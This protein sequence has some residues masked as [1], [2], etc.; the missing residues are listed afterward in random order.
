MDHGTPSDIGYVHVQYIQHCPVG[1]SV[2]TTN[3]DHNYTMSGSH[4]ACR[5]LVQASQ[6]SLDQV[7]RGTYRT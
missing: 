7:L 6:L 4:F 5:L 1:P 3:L 2:H